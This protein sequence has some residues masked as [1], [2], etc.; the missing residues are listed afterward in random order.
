MTDSDGALN[1]SIRPAA[2]GERPKQSIK[3]DGATGS[4]LLDALDKLDPPPTSIRDIKVRC[5]W[6]TGKA[7]EAWRLWQ[8]RE[9][10]TT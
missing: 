9:G 7:S 1:W 3:V 6:G 8:E 4:Q 5:T 10:V 2:D